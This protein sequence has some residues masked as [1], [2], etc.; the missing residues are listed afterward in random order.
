MVCDTLLPALLLQLF[1]NIDILLRMNGSGHV[2]LDPLIKYWV[3]DTVSIP[4][5]ALII[6]QYHHTQYQYTPVK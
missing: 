2:E 6:T 1:D 4:Y 5:T 3:Y